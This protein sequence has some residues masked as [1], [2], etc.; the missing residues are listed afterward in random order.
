[1]TTE[2]LNEIVEKA[3]QASPGPYTYDKLQNGEYHI[4]SKFLR[5][6]AKVVHPL[7]HQQTLDANF[8]A[9][10]KEDIYKLVEEVK[11]SWVRIGEL[12]EVDLTYIPKSIEDALRVIALQ[13]DRIALLA[14]QVEKSSN[15]SPKKLNAPGGLRIQ[16]NYTGVE[17]KSTPNVVDF[18]KRVASGA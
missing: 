7:E 11:E 13:R 17:L 16:P 9:S 12:E 8:F 10:A 3:D 4:Y 2:E 6:V 5:T 18:P 14:K 15:G 1:M